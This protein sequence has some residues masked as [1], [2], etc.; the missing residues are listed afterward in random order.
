MEQRLSGNL[1]VSFEGVDGDALLVALPDL[2]VSTSSACA[3]HGVS[4]SHVLEAI[5]VPPELLQSATR[6][7]LGRFTTAEEVEYAG[8]RV[9]EVVRKLRRER[10]A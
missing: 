7:G 1:N 3:S 4:G 10:P 6:F 2:A 5:G 8:R 9:V